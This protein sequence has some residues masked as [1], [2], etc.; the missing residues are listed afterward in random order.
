MVIDLD[1]V[2]QKETAVAQTLFIKV[3]VLLVRNHKNIEKPSIN[4]HTNRSHTQYIYKILVDGSRN[5]DF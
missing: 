4:I 3:P 5:L 2:L 1:T